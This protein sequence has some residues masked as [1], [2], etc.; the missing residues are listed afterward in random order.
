MRRA[1][2]KVQNKPIAMGDGMKYSV[3][4]LCGQVI[5]VN[6]ENGDVYTDDNPELGIYGNG[7][8]LLASEFE[9]IMEKENV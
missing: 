2:I 1:V 8:I 9:I 6:I 4:E 7:C 3:Q 5:T